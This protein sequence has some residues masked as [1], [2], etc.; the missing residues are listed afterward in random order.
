M[1]NSQPSRY[2]HSTFKES[3][4]NTVTVKR[5]TKTIWIMR[6]QH[7]LY[8]DFRGYS[9]RTRQL[10]EATNGRKKN[11]HWIE[12]TKAEEI[13]ESGAHNGNQK[14]TS[15]TQ[16]NTITTANTY[17]QIFNSNLYEIMQIQ[18]AKFSKEISLAITCSKECP[19]LLTL[20]PPPNNQPNMWRKTTLQ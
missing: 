17:T 4:R 13:T 16:K 2:L 6:H 20:S 10:R 19:E 14:D 1:Q 8:E 3:R 18:M 12:E 15:N 5:A 11:H 9:E 7:H